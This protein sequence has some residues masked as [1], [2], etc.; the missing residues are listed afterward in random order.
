M[1]YRSQEQRY[2]KSGYLTLIQLLDK[3]RNSRSNNHH[4]D[5]HYFKMFSINI[6]KR[7]DFT[8]W[9]HVVT[10]PPEVLEIITIRRE[11]YVNSCSGAGRI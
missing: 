7:Q 11:S 6:K 8:A 5:W 10:A 3:T 2:I 4:F 9:C 1:V